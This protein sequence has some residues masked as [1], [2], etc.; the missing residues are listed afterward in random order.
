[1]SS[2]GCVEADYTLLGGHP[3]TRQGMTAH[4]RQQLH[5]WVPITVWLP[6]YR[7]RETFPK[8]L[9]GAMTLGFILV[10]QSLA[11]ADLCGV[12]VINGPYSCMLPP[13]VYAIFGTCVHGSVGTGGLVA[14][15]T[16]VQL[17][18]YGDLEQRTHAAG[19]FSL[20]VGAVLTLMGFL[21]LAFMV[22]FLSRPALSG[23]V[24]ASAL[25]IM[26]SCVVAVL[27][28]PLGLGHEGLITKL[29][30]IASCTPG[31]VALSGF[32]LA[33]LLNARLLARLHWS[34][35]PLND[36]KELFAL[37][38]TAVFCSFHAEQLRIEVVGHVPSGLPGFSLPMTL[39]SDVALA[40][41]MLP[42]AA[43]VALVTFL[44]SFAG[45]KKFGMLDGY[46]VDATSELL[47]LG[48][49]NLSGAFCKGVP[50][51][52]GL[53]RL[54]IARAAGVQTQ[55]GANVLV[56]VVVT[57]VVWLF[58]ANLFFVPR[59]TLNCIIL[60]GASHLTEFSEAKA[61]YQLHT[62]WRQRKD[63]AVWLVAFLSTAFIGAFEGI[64]VAVAVSLVLILYQVAQPPIRVLGN[65]AGSDRW[66]AIG[67]VGVKKRPGVLAFRVEGPI[68]YANAEHIQDHLEQMELFETDLGNS[69]RA[70]VF[71]FSAVAFL[72]STA[73]QVLRAML[74]SHTDRGIAFFI[75]NSFGKAQVLLE[76]C[77]RQSNLLRQESLE[78]SVQECLDLW[79]KQ[80][81][82]R[83]PSKPKKLVGLPEISASV[84]VGRLSDREAL[85]SHRVRSLVHSSEW[86]CSP[87]A[88][89]VGEEVSRLH[90]ARFFS[91]EVIEH[92]E[93]HR[94]FV[95]HMR[96]RM[97]KTLG[98]LPEV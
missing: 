12:S 73:V 22:R 88:Y 28:L 41:E 26:E 35:K 24:T 32:T 1:M 7:W 64:I 92:D 81:A 29:L 56:A 93:T 19:I 46:T 65:V 77:L 16:G 9:A 34:L 75:A 49:C 14:L 53:S 4:L 67:Q 82:D 95:A 36:F 30:H 8:D 52:V 51:Q 62:D 37:L 84:P 13:I 55:L 68:F 42:G 23:F 6:K 59:C 38:L 66:L 21:R 89:M 10:A 15:L 45:A 71:S 2:D 47:A 54:G 85:R 39:P 40:K 70:I 57:L 5:K 3:A 61:L 72:D 69:I 44:S 20:E 63:L 91:G 97:S 43:L 60:L 94:P 58:S 25:L 11:H 74:Q 83:S 18:R 96:M 78:I 86:Q 31:T 79:D 87:A 90:S 27:G 48:L 50:T 17:R 98:S 33:L 80:E 76:L